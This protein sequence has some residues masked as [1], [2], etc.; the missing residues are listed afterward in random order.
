LE[1]GRSGKLEWGSID[2]QETMIW[3][4]DAVCMDNRRWVGFLIFGNDK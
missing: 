1:K 2:L 4:S 3:I